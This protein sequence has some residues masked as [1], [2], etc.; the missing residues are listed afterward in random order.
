MGFPTDFFPVL[1]A[2]PRTAGWL[3]HWK[4]SMEEPS[5]KLWR[6]RQVYTG[7]RTRHWVPMAQ[8]TTADDGKEAP[9]LAMSS[10]PF[11][12]RYLVSLQAKL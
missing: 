6:P 3:A 10:H 9:V 2:I 7:Q 4:E 11:N 1:F 8:R 12:R 5:P